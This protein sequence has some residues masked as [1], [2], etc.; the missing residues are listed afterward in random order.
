M[1]IVQHWVAG[2]G[3]DRSHKVRKSCILTVAGHL[4]LES[5]GSE[6]ECS[7]NVERAL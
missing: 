5:Y 1:P 7:F 3:I 6:V 2:L 4:V